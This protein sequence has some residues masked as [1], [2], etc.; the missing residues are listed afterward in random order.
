MERHTAEIQIEFDVPP[1]MRDGTALR[2]DAHRPGAAERASWFRC[3]GTTATA[4]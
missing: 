4:S 2:A 1:E 3:Q